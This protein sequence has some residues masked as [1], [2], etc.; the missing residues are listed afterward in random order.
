MRLVVVIALLVLQASTSNV[1]QAQGSGHLGRWL[2]VQG[3]FG[4]NPIP[5]E[6]QIY[7]SQ[8]A[9]LEA[10]IGRHLSIGLDY[11]YSKYTIPDPEEMQ[12]LVGARG[13]KFVA[14]KTAL[15]V[16][17][18]G[19]HTRVYFSNAPSPIGMFGEIG[20]GYCQYQYTDT[21]I[22]NTQLSP[23]VNGSA[24]GQLLA[25]RPQSHYDYL[26]GELAFGYQWFMKNR[27]MLTLMGSVAFKPSNNPNVQSNSIDRY[28]KGVSDHRV[29]EANAATLSIRL[30]YLIK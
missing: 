1:A 19:V 21:L 6:G 26:Y 16:Q 4:A 28:L 11:R 3:H 12:Y 30:G 29:D 22:E 20:V 27:I 23:L 18:V 10:F 25:I 13:H 2:A 15:Q 5:L 9:G 7:F 17:R 8:G 24:G 14:D